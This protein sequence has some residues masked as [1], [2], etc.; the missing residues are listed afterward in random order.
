M[1]F[2]KKYEV[3]E[4]HDNGVRITHVLKGTKKDVNKDIEMY[5]EK[6]KDFMVIGKEAMIVWM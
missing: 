6:C 4:I 2:N 5:K 3:I 1:L